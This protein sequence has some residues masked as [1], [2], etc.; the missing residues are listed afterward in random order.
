MTFTTSNI[1]LSDTGQFSRLIIDYIRKNNSL[2]SFYTYEPDSSSFEQAIADRN[3]QP[4]DRVLLVEALK[5]QYEKAGIKGMHPVIEKLKDENTFTVCT[6]HQLCLFTGPLYFIYKL[7]STINL[8][9]ALKKRYPAFNFVP[10][11]WMATEDHDFEEICSINLFNKTIN[12]DNAHASGAV[13]RLESDSLSVLL[14]ELKTILGDSADALKLAE[15]FTKAYLNHSNLADATRY[16]VHE[17]FGMYGLLIIDGDHQQLKKSFASVIEDD[18][19]NN[20]NYR[21]VNQTIAE[22]EKQQVK[23]QVNPRPVN[24]FYMVDHLRERIESDGND[25]Y[26]V[27]NTSITFTKETL[28]KELKAHP[29]RFSPNVVLRPLYQQKILPNLAYVGGPGELAYWLE[30]KAMFDHHNI[31]FPVLVPRNF[32]LLMDEKTEQQLAKAGFEIPDLFK[33]TEV[34]IKELVTRNTTSQLSLA[35][36]QAKLSDV[37]KEIANVATAIDSTLKASVEA[38]FQ[39]ASNSIKNIESKILR[40]EKQNQ[41][42]GINQIKKIKERFF[43]KDVLQERYDNFIPYYLKYGDELITGLKAVFDPFAFQ[44]LILTP[45]GAASVKKEAELKKVK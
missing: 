16:L 41:E 44:L 37:F 19:F 2:K 8:S 40:S 17:L 14:S 6:G 13:G 10:V 35:E 12:W 34:L 38:E 15:L 42:T 18:L 24:C 32:A 9:E 1:A 25:T 21:L 23:A 45:S 39:K 27:V 31:Q 5:V 30:Y 3:K 11:Y 20:T 7:I 22:L 36:Q 43:P 4:L 33:D 28:L 29:E 26:S